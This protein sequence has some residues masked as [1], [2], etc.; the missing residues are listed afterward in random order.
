[1]K[2]AE[3]LKILNHLAQLDIDSVHAYEKVIDRVDDT[4]IRERLAHF[5]DDHKQHV[6]RLRDEIRARGGEAPGSS[7]DFKGYVVEGFMNMAEA[8]GVADALK[9]L[10]V[11]EEITNQAYSDV[12]SSDLAPDL[13]E[14][15]REYFSD[16]KIHLHYIVSNS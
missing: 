3:V 8:V 10:E 5:R 7:R 6:E 2:D 11:V 15:I 14:I 4:V 16:E 13:K 12:I 9:V 1:M